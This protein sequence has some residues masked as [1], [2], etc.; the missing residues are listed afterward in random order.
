MLDLM[1]R[2]GLVVTPSGAGE[3]DVV[4][5]EDLHEADYSPWEGYDISGWPE[6]TILCGKVVVD[7]GKF[8][9]QA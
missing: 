3:F 9:G 2:G 1:V 7:R 8:L 6:T 5:V 4:Q